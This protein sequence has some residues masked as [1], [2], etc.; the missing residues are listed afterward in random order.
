MPIIVPSHTRVRVPDALARAQPARLRRR[1]RGQLPAPVGV[2]GRTPG[3]NDGSMPIPGYLLAACTGS[4]HRVSLQ[5]RIPPRWRYRRCS[6]PPPDAG[7]PENAIG[8]LVDPVPIS[9]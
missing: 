9:M 6:G 5:A 7:I 2:G 3:V 8:S 4:I 1:G